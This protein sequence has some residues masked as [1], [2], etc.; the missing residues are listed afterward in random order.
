MIKI[1]EM[2]TK[3]LNIFIHAG[4]QLKRSNSNDTNNTI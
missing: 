3:S 2:I 4:I 1:P